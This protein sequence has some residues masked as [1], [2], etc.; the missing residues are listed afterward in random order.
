[1]RVLITG[2]SGQLATAFASRLERRGDPCLALT[3]SQLDITNPAAVHEAFA[4]FRPDV[5]LNGAAYNLVDRAE[6]APAD[7]FAVNRDAVALLAA[8]AR[9]QGARLVHYSTDYVFD[10]QT[11]TPYDEC[12]PTSPLSAYGR[13]KLAGEQVALESCARCLVLR[14]SWVFGNSNGGQNFFN[15]LEQWSRSPVP[16]RMAWDQISIPT[17]TEDIVSTTLQALEADL[18]GLWHL[19]SSGYASR[20]EMARFFLKAICRDRIVLP[21]DSSYF[22]PAAQRPF[23]SALSNRR[24]SEAL[25]IRIPDWE[26]AVLR[27]VR[28]RQETGGLA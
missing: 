13:S 3:R 26:E 24:L 8:A 14:V 7:A 18:D 22:N 5:I 23:F 19:T 16:L 28:H 25:Q 4:G 17:Y 27:F 20:Y 1:M 6:E 9:R 12:S 10:G 11:E 15:K 2:A 21:A